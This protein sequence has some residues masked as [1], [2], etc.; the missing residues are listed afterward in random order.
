[1][2]RLSEAKERA[3]LVK[4]LRKDLPAVVT[5]RHE[6]LMTAGIPDISCSLNRK[7][8]WIET[9]VHDLKTTGIQYETLRRLKGFYIVFN[10]DIISIVDVST[11]VVT[12]TNLAGVVELVRKALTA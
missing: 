6:D 3:K 4:R 9:K 11:D 1:M 12:Q 10:Y 2:G 5:I 8:I 7:T